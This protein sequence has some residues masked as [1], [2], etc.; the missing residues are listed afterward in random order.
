MSMKRRGSFTV[1]I[2]K[3]QSAYRQQAGKSRNLVPQL[4]FIQLRPL[5]QSRLPLPRY[6]CTTATKL[7]LLISFCRHF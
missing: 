4:V 6:P 1:I 3:I 5:L 7:I 2:K